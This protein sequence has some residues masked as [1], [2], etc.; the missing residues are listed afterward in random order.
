MGYLKIEPSVL[1]GEIVIPPS[2]SLAHRYVI[3][4]GLSEGES[5]IQNIDLSVDIKATMGCMKALGVSFDEKKEMNNRVTLSV[6]GKGRH[7]NLEDGIMNCEESGS[8]LR[9]MIPIALL[10]EK[11]VVFTGKGKL[12][13]RPLTVYYDIFSEKGISYSTEEEGKLPLKVNGELTHGTYR[14]PGNISSQFI[15]GLLFALPLV[16]GDSEIIVEGKFESKPYVDLTVDVLKRF[17]VNIEEK[18]DRYLVPGNQSYQGGSYFVEGDFSQ[19]AFFAVAGMIGKEPVVCK[20]LNRESLQGDR[21]IIDIIRGMGG[22]VEEL[23]DGYIFFPTKTKGIVIDVFLCPDLVPALGLLGALSEGETRIINGERL[24]LKESN[25]LAA[26]A[27]ELGT[28]G[29]DITETKDGLIIKGVK[30]LHGG[31]VKSHNDHRI[32]MTLAMASLACDG[33]IYLEGY[34]SVNK[35]YPGFWEDFNKLGGRWSNE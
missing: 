2:K 7:F 23:E 27:S 11:E 8:T 31:K 14:I 29:A 19:V 24:R 15:T 35:S 16:D 33:D 4:A 30:G 20:G 25:R 5:T 3:S 26:V 13:E 34:E 12:V 18:G 22:F 17:G 6:K 32:A 28:L 21:A 1:S 9:F 10:Q